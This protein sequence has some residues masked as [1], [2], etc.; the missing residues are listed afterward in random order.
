MISYDL[1]SLQQTT[2]FQIR[3]NDDGSQTTVQGPT[4][5]HE[6][7]IL[8]RRKSSQVTENYRLKKRS[9]SPL[10]ENDYLWSVR[11][12]SGLIKTVERRLAQNDEIHR[13]RPVLRFPLAWFSDEPWPDFTNLE[14]KILND[15]KGQTWNAP[16]TVIEGRKTLDMA[17]NA[18]TRLGAGMHALK[19]GHFGEFASLFG[20]SNKRTER[21]YNARFGRDPSGAAAAAWMEGRYGWMPVLYD[22]HDAAATLADLL[23]T[24]SGHWVKLSAREHQNVNESYSFTIEAD[25]ALPLRI[26]SA[27][28]RSL[29]MSIWYGRDVELAAPKALGLSNPAELAFEL[30]PLSFVVDWFIPIGDYLSTFNATQGLTFQKGHYSV[31]KERSTTASGRSE[32]NF[33][34]SGSYQYYYGHS[35]RRRMVGFPNPSFP[36]FSLRPNLN[37]FIDSLAL[38]RQIFGKK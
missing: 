24:E 14:I 36:N 12:R 11:S 17:T 13:S 34:C 5:D 20:L 32:E 19:R 15:V 21:R 9:R 33:S 2:S 6:G 4:F 30:F 28:V 23:N 25:P 7:A 1:T 38:T 29:K 26:D 27:T 31:R 37:R 35:E 8:Q 16:Q 10:P 18:V 3:N 22:I